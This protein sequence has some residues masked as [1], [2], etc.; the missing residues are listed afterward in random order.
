MGRPSGCP[1]FFEVK[2]SEVNLS[3][4]DRAEYSEHAERLLEEIT[5]II[6]VYE[7]NPEDLKSLRSF[8]KAMDRMQMQAKLYELDLIASFCEMGKLVADKAT[9][10]TSQI[11]NEVAAGVL[12]DTVDVLMQMI[13]SIKIGEDISSMKQF[14]S[15]IGRL[16]IL[17]DKFK[18]LS[19]DNDIEK[20]DAMVSDLEKKD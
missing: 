17:V 12:A 16:R 1:F 18:S 7:E 11:L 8:H 10:S 4:E 15:F 20:L 14:G 6:E 3:D 19:A 9:K 5:S 13:Q 2:L